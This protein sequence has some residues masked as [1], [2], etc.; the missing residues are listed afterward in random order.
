MNEH[1]A[2]EIAF[3]NGYKQGIEDLSKKLEERYSKI[4]LWGSVAVVFMK[5]I[6]ENLEKRNP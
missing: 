2:T 4:P 3:R 6:I 1:D 5:E